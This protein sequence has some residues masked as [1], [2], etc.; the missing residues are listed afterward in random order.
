LKK[1]IV[2]IVVALLV[3]GTQ[4]TIAAAD[5]AFGQCNP[6]EA[7]CHTTV[8]GYEGDNPWDGQGAE[9]VNTRYR[10]DGSTISYQLGGGHN[11]DET[12]GGG[13]LYCSDRDADLVFD[14]SGGG[15]IPPTL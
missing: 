2:W 7:G 14:C 4:A 1:L 15:S 11:T 13:G 3:A 6:N 8:A 12:Q 10:P 9:V 5:T